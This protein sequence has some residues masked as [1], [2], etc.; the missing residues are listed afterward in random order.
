M[1][2]AQEQRGT[3]RVAVRRDS[4]IEAALHLSGKRL[5]ATVGNISA[6]GIFLRLD[7]GPIAAL[8]VE[9]QL[10]VEISFEHGVMVLDVSD[11]GPGIAASERDKVFDKFYRGQAAKRND[12]GTGLGLTI[13]RAVARAH[14]GD[15]CIL[16]RAGGGS[17]VRFSLPCPGAVRADLFQASRR[18]P[19]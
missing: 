8:K 16:P 5:A 6:E 13:C 11:R 7:R 9:R 3:F 19:A 1:K 17:T 14:D 18:L 15:I 12:G 4:G 2:L 10:D